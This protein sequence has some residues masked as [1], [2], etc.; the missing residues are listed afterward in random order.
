[1]KK[2][3]NNTIYSLQKQEDASVQTKVIRNIFPFILQCQPHALNLL[4]GG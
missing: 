2:E 1:M 4:G 3:V